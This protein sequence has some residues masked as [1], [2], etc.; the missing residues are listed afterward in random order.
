MRAHPAI[1]TIPILGLLGLAVLSACQ[2]SVD[3]VNDG[4][5]KLAS[6]TTTSQEFGDYVV[7][8]NAFRTDQLSSEIAKIYGIV[9]SKERAMLNVS[10]MKKEEGKRAAAVPGVVTATATNLTGQFKTA[11]VREIREGMAIYYIAELSVANAEILTF[12]IE[13][14]PENESEPFSIRFQ[15]QFFAD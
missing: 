8:F 3:S 15:K 5:T 10:I 6:P 2:Q 14:I 9:R 13:V 7:H 4:E 1:Q 11:S 12:K